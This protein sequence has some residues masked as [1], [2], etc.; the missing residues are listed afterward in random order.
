MEGNEEQRRKKAREARRR[1]RVA[2]GEQATQGASRQRHH[3]PE[4]ADHVEKLPMIRAGKQPD[5]GIHVSIPPP[6]P[7][8]RRPK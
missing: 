7:R 3:L 5:P 6:R 8:S 1:G 2:S 4:D